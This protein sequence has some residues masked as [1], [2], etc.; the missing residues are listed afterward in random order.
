MALSTIWP[1]PAAPP[2]QC[3][4]TQRLPCDPSTVYRRITK[5]YL[6]TVGHVPGLEE[7]VFVENAETANAGCPV[8]RALA[9]VPEIML[10]ASLTP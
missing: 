4:P 2:N 9:G 6:V 10:V 1:K 5:I 3:T 8:S 7:S